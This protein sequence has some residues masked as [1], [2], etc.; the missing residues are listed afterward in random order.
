MKNKLFFGK[1]GYFEAHYEAI[2]SGGD[3]RR[4]G[5]ELE[6]LF[7]DL[8]KAGLM[9]GRPLEDDRRLMDLTGT[10]HEDDSY[11]LY[12]RLDRLSLT[13]L[14]KWGVVSIGR[15][16]VTWGNG[17]LFNPMDLFNPFSPADIERD[18]KVGD[19][20][21]STQFSVNKIGEFQFLYVPRRD[22]VRENVQW[23]QSSLAAK[24]HFAWGTTEF[25]IMAAKHYKD[26]VIGFGS[27]GYLGDAAWRLDGVWTF[28]NE[29]RGKKGY[30]SLVANMDY[31]W[32]WWG[33]NF[34]GFIEFYFNGLSH[35]EY[36]EAFTG[37]DISERLDRGELF[38][39]GRTYLSGHIRV[40]LHP[41]FNVYLTVIN[42]L[43]DPSGIIQP[44]AVWDI[45]ED[46]QITF[47]GNIYYGRRGT[48]YGGFK[49]PG[50]NFLNKAPDSVFL[51]LTY[52]F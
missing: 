35:N 17:L 4:K 20:M 49:I 27:T 42:N 48:E 19:D 32:V 31:S 33:K 6:R 23:N 39:L 16:A 44:R 11:I 26:A 9:I 34:Y 5:K 29:D 37:P 15:Q 22:L 1:W 28:L 30:L 51:W 50:T 7:P 41:L 38:T 8:F 24:L 40:E 21:V 14:P 25:D 52:Y 3:T 2:L 10:I 46:V 13:L 12:H 47:G 45:F 18:Y 36:T 43:A